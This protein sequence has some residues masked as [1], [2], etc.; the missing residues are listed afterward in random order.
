MDLRREEAGEERRR[1]PGREERRDLSEKERD[2]QS[3]RERGE[4]ARQRSE[5]E[6]FFHLVGNLL[7]KDKGNVSFM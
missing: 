5:G 2:I 1:E 4:T 6:T 3:R 7:L